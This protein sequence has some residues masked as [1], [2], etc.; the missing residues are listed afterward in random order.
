[1]QLWTSLSKVVYRR[2]LG[3]YKIHK[4]NKNETIKQ[5]NITAI[6]ECPNHCFD[7]RKYNT[8]FEWQK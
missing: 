6:Q 3:I 2:L 8:F 4:R 5:V 1:M 7:D